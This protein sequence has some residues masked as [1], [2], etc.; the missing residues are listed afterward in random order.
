MQTLATLRG[1]GGSLPVI[2]PAEVTTRVTHRV[3]VEVNYGYL[4]Y[5][6]PATGSFVVAW[7]Q[8]KS[9]TW[10]DPTK[11][12]GKRKGHTWY[13]VRTAGGLKVRILAIRSRTGKKATRSGCRRPSAPA[14]RTSVTSRVW[15]VSTVGGLAIGI[16]V[17]VGAA[18]ARL[19]LHR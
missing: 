8:F 12:D 19:V 18:D 7:Q 15:T 14:R 16:A 10:S 4:R 1:T 2:K 13:T 3:R 11:F 9:N 17:G 5:R 6:I